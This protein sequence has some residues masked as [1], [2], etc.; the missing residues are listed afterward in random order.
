MALFWIPEDE[1]IPENIG[2]FR[3]TA[4][5]CY[6]ELQE[7]VRIQNRILKG[8]RFRTKE[9][10]QAFLIQLITQDRHPIIAWALCNG[11]QLYDNIDDFERFRQTRWD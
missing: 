3:T 6:A 9:E 8:N 2:H 5:G 7:A 1:K 4:K 11:N 10:Q